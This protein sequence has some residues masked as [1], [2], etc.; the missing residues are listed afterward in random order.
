LATDR[1]VKE[2][3]VV[4][5]QRVLIM[6]NGHEDDSLAAHPG[7]VHRGV[8]DMIHATVA[9]PETLLSKQDDPASLM[10]GITHRHAASYAGHRLVLKDGIDVNG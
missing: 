6:R 5:R 7:G 8:V 9:A 2:L 10:A 3:A 1:G 4:E